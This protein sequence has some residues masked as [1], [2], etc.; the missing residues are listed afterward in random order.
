MNNYY[1]IYTVYCMRIMIA[2]AQVK[3]AQAQCART[4]SVIKGIDHDIQYIISYKYVIYI[5]YI[6]V[7]RHCDY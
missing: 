5:Y 2:L 3:H 1:N 4:D 7:I 6:S